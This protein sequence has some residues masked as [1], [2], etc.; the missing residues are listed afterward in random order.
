MYFPLAIIKKCRH[1]QTSSKSKAKVKKCCKKG[2]VRSVE[3]SESIQ[4]KDFKLK[5]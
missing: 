4:W 1:R 5:S 3:I 2:I